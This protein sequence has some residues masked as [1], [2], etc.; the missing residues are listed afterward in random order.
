MCLG[1]H[2]AFRALLDKRITAVVGFFATD[3]HS[4]SLGAGVND[5]SLERVS[6]EFDSYTQELVLF[7]GTLDSH[8]PPEGR[9][10]IR[11]TLRD[12]GVKF[13]FMEIA[14]AQHA[15]VRDEF[16]KGRY[17]SAITSSCLGFLFELFHRKLTIDLG[18]VE[19]KTEKIEHVC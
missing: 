1:G 9:D 4:K 7:F 6:K 19:R 13:T 10:L 17:D 2:L 16:S 3:I 14:D 18:D 12:H 11:K 8:V 15:Y 5:D